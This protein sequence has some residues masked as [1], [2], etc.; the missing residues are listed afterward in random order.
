MLFA[1]FL[2]VV[3]LLA[4]AAGTFEDVSARAAAARDANDV[5]KAIDLYKQAVE[6]NPRWEEGWWYLG[7]LLYDTDQYADGRDA[8]R[9]VVARDAKAGPAWALLGLC[10]FET[11][12]YAAAL[13]DMRRG[14]GAGAATPQMEGV[15]RYHEAL[16]LT[17]TGRFDEAL[18][19]YVW[20]ARKGVRNPELVSAMGL[21]ALRAPMLPQEIPV[22]QRELYEL[23][24]KAAYASTEGDFATAQRALSE[25]LERFPNAHYV[26][27]VYG[28]FLLAAKPALAMQELRR[29]L[30]IT[31]SSGAAN[32]MLAWMLL[33]HGDAE[34]ARA[35]AQNAVA[36]DPALPL[37][38]Y[39]CGRSL[40]EDG[41]L[42]ASI[43]HLQLAE[44]N[45]P[46]NLETHMS[47]ATAYS[48]GGRPE[49]ARRER[50]KT[51]EMWKESNATAN[52]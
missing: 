24:G 3:S 12:E 39:V 1:T 5:P 13:E 4:Q 49:E 18:R 37:A 47:L 20:F 8:L 14:L 43:Q 15:L 26:H 9:R 27:Y 31:P 34:H 38:Q 23:A 25:L 36:E 10:E 51:L 28:C 16:L 32:A 19:A 11:R 7:S 50:M 35:Y 6:L 30:E 40:L 22:D 17:R 29:E 45:D 41:K 52:P 48:R 2:F 46:L 44:K 42:E 33:E 21:A